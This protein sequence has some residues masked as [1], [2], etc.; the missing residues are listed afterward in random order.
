MRRTADAADPRRSETAARLTLSSE[1][2]Q[3]GGPQARL[4]GAEVDRRPERDARDGEDGQ[5]LEHFYI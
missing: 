1:D 4:T 2:R 5:S 3:R